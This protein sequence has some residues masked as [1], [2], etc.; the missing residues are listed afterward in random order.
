MSEFTV[1][2]VCP[3]RVAKPPDLRAGTSELI[4][5]PRLDQ[6]E[7]NMAG[8]RVFRTVLCAHKNEEVVQVLVKG[9]GTRRARACVA[10]IR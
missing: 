10:V 3:H 1:S 8:L 7:G 5:P 9:E 4:E 6:D 2:E